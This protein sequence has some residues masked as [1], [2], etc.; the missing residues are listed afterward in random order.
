MLGVLLLPLWIAMIA[1]DAGAAE[2]SSFVALTE[3]VG[4]GAA[5]P[6]SSNPADPREDG[7]SA[8]EEDD[9]DTSAAEMLPAAGA[10]HVHPPGARPIRLLP[11]SGASPPR[12]HL[13]AETPPPRP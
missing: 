12:V 3:H 10:P 5:D 6:G 9:D 11:R 7:A 8:I 1:T 13:E 4:A 2:A